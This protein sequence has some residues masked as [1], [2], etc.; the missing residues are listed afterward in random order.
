MTTQTLSPQF[1]TITEQL[2]NLGRQFEARATEFDQGCQFVSQ[3]YADLRE[4]RF[5][6]LAIPKEFGGAGLAYA[7][8]CQVT[9]QLARHCGSTALA[10]AMHSHPVALNVFKALKGDARSQAT[11]EKIAGNELIIAGTGAND[12]LSSNGSAVAVEGGFIVNAHKRFVSGG[13]GAQ[14]LVSS[15]NFEGDSGKEVLHFSLPFST[16]GIQIQNNWRTLGMRGTG[17]NDVILE[18]VFLPETAVVARRPAGVWHPIWDTI[19]PIALPLITSAYMGMAEA[20][21]QLALEASAGRSELA[22][23]VGEMHNQLTTAQMAVDDLILRNGDYQFT[24]SANN[25]EAVLCRKTIANKAILKVV[26]LAATLVGGS[27]F[28]QGHPMER[29]VRDVRA[30]QFHPLPEHKQQVFSGRVLLGID[31]VCEII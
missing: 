23:L 18:N 24:P 17:S 11:L 6:S 16:E 22:G 4:A 15:V 29:I 27:G 5:F 14:V 28:F 3:N 2:E 13:P 31:P 21:Y 8:V 20:A 30:M 19:L 12:W 9:R 7:Q 10:Y 25:T 26:D 1:A